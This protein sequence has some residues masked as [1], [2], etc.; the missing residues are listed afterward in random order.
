MTSPVERISGPKRM[1]TPGKRLNGKDR[2]LDAG[3][4][5]LRLLEL[6]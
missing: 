6:E 3:M 4:L 2:F 5:E 1:S